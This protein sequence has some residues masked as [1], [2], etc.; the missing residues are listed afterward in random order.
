MKMNRFMIAML[1]A[2]CATSASAFP[3]QR[4]T[5]IVPFAPG[6]P[7]DVVTRLVFQD[8]SVRWGQPVVIENRTGAGGLVGTEAV[9]RAK[10]DG[11]TLL[12]QGGAL[13][14]L[15]LFSKD[16]NFDPMTDL[17]AVGPFGF[18]TY[19]VVIHP[20]L[21]AKSWREFVALAKAKP[22]SLN[23]GTIPLTGFDLDL[24][25]FTQ[26]AGIEMGAVPY[27]GA[28]PGMVALLRNDIQL[29]FATAGASAQAI[30]DGKLIALAATGAKRS[31]R[32]P[33][34]PTLIESGVDYTYATWNG[35][36]APGKTPDSVV[37][38]IAR[39]MTTVL[40]QPAIISRLKEFGIEAPGASTPQQFN[41]LMQGVAK[42]YA[43]L[44]RKLG[45]Q[46]Q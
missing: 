13:T 22:K 30:A 18:T 33:A 16:V 9:A 23:Y 12:F 26:A 29:Y 2:A 40:Q 4:V 44:A 10:P 21:P 1:L 6:G 35:I 24:V 15:K 41:E 32:F 45:I 17:R 46:P 5:I 43:E 36:F 20:S 28:A 25:K 19:V 7:S 38:L 14:T 31:D 11:H 37:N 39:E 42:M 8:I 27:A 34:L 3:D